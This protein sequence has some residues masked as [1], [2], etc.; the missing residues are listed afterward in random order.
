MT[1]KG[2]AVE[3]N[4]EKEEKL[5]TFANH[6]LRILEEHKNWDADTTDLIASYAHDLGLSEANEYHEFVRKG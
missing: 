1:S 5:I 3:T 4:S 2:Q 6:T